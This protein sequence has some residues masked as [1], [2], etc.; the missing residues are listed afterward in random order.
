MYDQGHSKKRNFNHF[1]KKPA[2]KG[3]M[4]VVN[5]SIECTNLVAELKTECT[6]KKSS[7]IR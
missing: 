7:S 5:S 4:R 6:V 3:L 1:S 2:A